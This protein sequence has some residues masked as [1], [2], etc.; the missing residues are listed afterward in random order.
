M[1]MQSVVSTKKRSQKLHAEFEGHEQALHAKTK[2]R[3]KRHTDNVQL[4]LL[5][6]LKIKQTKAMS[7]V[8]MF[9]ELPPDAIEAILERTKY[10]KHENGEVLCQQ[11]DLADYF[12]IIVSGDCSVHVTQGENE[13][14]VGSLREL[15]FFGEGVLVSGGSGDDIGPRRN[16]TVKV[17][18]ENVQVLKLTAKDLMMLMQ[19]GVLTNEMIREVE[20]TNRTRAELTKRN[21]ISMAATTKENEQKGPYTSD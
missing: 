8:P 19:R 15:E 21:S 16:A 10:G 14:R 3:Q 11:G 13:Q 1:K 20:E 4:R 7:K 6:R 9:K 12:Y 2:K 18:S 5:A 17:E